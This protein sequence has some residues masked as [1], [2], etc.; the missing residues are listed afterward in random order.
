MFTCLLLNLPV[1]KKF[2]LVRILIEMSNKKEQDEFRRNISS[3]EQE[4]DPRLT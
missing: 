1:A 3:R 2:L 4:S